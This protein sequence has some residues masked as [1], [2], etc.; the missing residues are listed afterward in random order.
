[1]SHI[2]VYGPHPGGPGMTGQAACMICGFSIPR[3]LLQ[4]AVDQGAIT[5]LE[6]VQ[7]AVPFRKRAAAV[8]EIAQTVLDLETVRSRG[9]DELDFPELGI[10]QIRAALEAAFEAGRLA[11]SRGRPLR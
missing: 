10:W 2:H 7:P 6:A 3:S 9:R 11:G 5:S 4:A 1:M 8:A